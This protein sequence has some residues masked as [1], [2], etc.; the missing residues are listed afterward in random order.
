MVRG[1]RNKQ[2]ISLE[3]I[4]FSPLERLLVK[5]YKKKK[6]EREHQGKREE[7]L[8]EIFCGIVIVIIPCWTLCE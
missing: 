7:F 2:S 1:K 8:R 3:F 5:I 4:V 6:R